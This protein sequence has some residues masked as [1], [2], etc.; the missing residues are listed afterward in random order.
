MGRLTLLNS[1]K[2]LNDNDFKM[3][4]HE[5]EV[6][7]PNDFVEFYKLHNGGNPEQTVLKDFYGKIDD[8]EIGDF[9]PIRYCRKFKDD[10]DFTLDGR[11][12]GEWAENEVPQNLLPYAMD[13]G[14]NY[15]C[16]GLDDGI[17]YYFNRFDWNDELSAEQNLSLN[18]TPIAPSFSCFIDNLQY[19]GEEKIDVTKKSFAKKQEKSLPLTLRDSEKLLNDNDFI[20]IEQ[21]LGITLPSDFV[22]FYKLHNGGIPNRTVIEDYYEKIDDVEISEFFPALYC[23]EFE[24]D[25]DYT[26][27]GMAKSEWAENKLPK[28]LLPF[29]RDWGDNYICIRLDDGVICYFVRDVWRDNLSIEDNFFVNTTPITPSFSYCVENLQHNLDDDE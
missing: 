14:G 17:I 21:D 28:N 18:T 3:V 23:Q 12:K 20:R 24:N 2:S 29:A 4:E 11:V 7:L 25:P 6:K 9:M 19:S 16:L 1:E 26:L 22:E 8:I 15:I 13:C 10:P 5:L 27:D